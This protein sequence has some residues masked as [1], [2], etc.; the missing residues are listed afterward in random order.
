MAF[1]LAVTA[2]AAV[3]V[4]ALSPGTERAD[5]AIVLGAP[6]AAA[7]PAGFACAACKAGSAMGFRQ[8]ALHGATVEAPEGGV[9]VSAR[10][11]A[12]RIAGSEAPRIAVLRPADGITATIVDSAPLPVSS[13]GGALHEVGDLHLA[14]EPGD[15]LGFLLRAGQVDLG[16]RKRPTPDGAVVSFALPCG[17]CGVDGGTGTELLLSGTLEPD[18]DGDLLGDESQDPD[19]GGAFLDE[20]FG[21]PLDEA[22]YDDEQPRRARRGPLRLVRV[23]RGHAGGATLLLATPRAGRLTATA[24]APARRRRR[25]TPAGTARRTIALGRARAVRAGRVRLRL[26]P[27]RAGRRLLARRVRVRTRLVVGFDP[28]RGRRQELTRALRLGR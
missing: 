4:P 14:V 2:L 22:I 8:L 1:R 23:T 15:S 24:T 17:P 26:R 20:A 3:L 13:R 12:K 10:A 21:E 9:L 11:Y 27:S 5:A 7:P 25:S 19:G 6:D 28:A 16:A 18:Y